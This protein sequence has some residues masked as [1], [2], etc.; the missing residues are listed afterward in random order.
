[1]IQDGSGWKVHYDPDISKP[2]AAMNKVMAAMGEM[3]TWKAFDAIQADMLV[4]RGANS[5]LLSAKT[6]TEM[7]RRR[8]RTR[9]IEIPGVGH[10]PA[11]ITPE[12][13]AIAREFFS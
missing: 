4:V 9:S 1:L 12:Q 10:A 3:M 13:V 8:P 2:F 7:C 11:F 6:V 5:D